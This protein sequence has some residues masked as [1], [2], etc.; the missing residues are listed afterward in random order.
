MAAGANYWRLSVDP[1]TGEPIGLARKI[2]QWAGFCLG[3]TSATADGKKLVFTE[4]AE[5]G[6][7]YVGQLQRG[8]TRLAAAQR[9]SLLEGWTRP[10]GWTP[11]S[12]AVFFV[13][14]NDGAWGLYKQAL[15]TESAERILGGL[16]NIPLQTPVTP[17]GNWLLYIAN[18]DEQDPDSPQQLMRVPITGGHPE[19]I[20][21]GRLRS[22]RCPQRGLCV[23]DEWSSDH[24]Q[25]LLFRLEPSRGKSSELTRLDAPGTSNF[26]WAISPDGTQ[27]AVFNGRLPIKIVSLHDGSVLH[28]VRIAD[29]NGAD[30][31]M[32]TNDATGM[33][34]STP[35]QDGCV[36]LRVNLK[37][38]V[39]V[40]WEQRGGLSTAAIP[41][42]DGRHLAMLGW[43][44]SSNAWMMQ[45]F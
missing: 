34:V 41:S 8:G 15:G 39:Q 22:V 6:A 7:V 38:R 13:S 23:F 31:L 5:R 11:D 20:L 2:T 28:E 32:W 40:M 19:P 33:Y 27:I 35:V 43:T 21:S 9:L 30:N 12:K 26:D 18:D 24:K 45:N 3:S 1:R 14:N 25:V 44:L 4:P 37:G 29:W 16:R 10:T 17:D 36:L 42:P